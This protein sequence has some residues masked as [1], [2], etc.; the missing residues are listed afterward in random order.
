MPKFTTG[1]ICIKKDRDNYYNN[2]NNN[3][4]TTI[5]DTIEIEYVIENNW[6]KT[7]F[8]IIN[9]QKWPIPY[10]EK[11]YKMMLGSLLKQL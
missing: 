10:V 4:R 1:S 11:Y 2:Y 7:S 5:Y 3:I 8:Y 6:T 9:N